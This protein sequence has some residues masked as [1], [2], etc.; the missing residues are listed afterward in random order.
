MT[1]S[2]EEICLVKTEEDFSIVGFVAH[3]N[4]VYAIKAPNGRILA[5]ACA[6]DENL[7]DLKEKL[8]YYINPK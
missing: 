7:E 2:T 6:T 8:D 3:G 1:F 5:S 4:S